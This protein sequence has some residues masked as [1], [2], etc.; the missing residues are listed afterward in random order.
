[1]DFEYF[2]RPPALVQKKKEYENFTV[3]PIGGPEEIL[4]WRAV[5]DSKDQAA[6]MIHE[7]LRTKAKEQAGSGLPQGDGVT[8]KGQGTTGSAE[9]KEKLAFAKSERKRL[10]QKEAVSLD[11]KRHTPLEPTLTFT[12]KI[13]RFIKNFWKNAN[14]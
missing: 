1:M 14:F 2:N 13:S 10:A 4:K 8:W 5:Q 11:W 7:G 9:W 6:L 12:Q 3:T